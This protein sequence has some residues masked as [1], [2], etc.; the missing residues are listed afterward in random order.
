MISQGL[1][2]GLMWT[3]VDKQ[4]SWLILMSLWQRAPWAELM[5]LIVTGNWLQDSQKIRCSSFCPKEAVGCVW[6]I[7]LCAL[8][9]PVYVYV[10]AY[11]WVCPWCRL[12]EKAVSGGLEKAVCFL[13][14]AGIIPVPVKKQ[15]MWRWKERGDGPSMNGKQCI[16]V[17]SH[18]YMAVFAFGFIFDFTIIC[19]FVV[20]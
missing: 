3:W 9:W 12:S 13:D 2:R 16:L 11:L 7:P 15:E 5:N 8:T 6:R 10:C 14:R 19:V 20:S 1:Q 17:S 4:K 18:R